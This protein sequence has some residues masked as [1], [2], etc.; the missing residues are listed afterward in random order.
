[1]LHF[2]SLAQRDA[3]GFTPILLPAVQHGVH[4]GDLL[5]NECHKTRACI[6][7]QL[8]QCPF[9]WQCR[10][11]AMGDQGRAV[12]LGS[13]HS[14]RGERSICLKGHPN[15]F[16]WTTDA[17]GGYRLQTP[18]SSSNKCKKAQFHC[19]DNSTP[20]LS[21]IVRGFKE[22]R[23]CAPSLSAWENLY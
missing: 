11:A 15:T 10:T 23:H 6:E 1:M 8:P 2:D 9:H 21:L 3:P 16:S 20:S 4:P 19:S 5:Q 17:A 22:Q 18:G 12:G 7:T 14:A 13:A